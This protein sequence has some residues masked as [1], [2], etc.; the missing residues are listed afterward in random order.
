M[1]NRTETPLGNLFERIEY[2]DLDKLDSFI[3]NLNYEQ[4]IF[5]IKVALELAYKSNIYTLEES[6][7]VSKALRIIST[8]NPQNDATIEKTN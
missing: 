3:T 6:E 4:S 8:H 5:C 7:V 1:E 2:F